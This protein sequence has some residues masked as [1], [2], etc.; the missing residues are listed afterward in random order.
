[1]NNIIIYIILLLYYE[2]I[3]IV[4]VSLGTGNLKVTCYFV[5]NHLSHGILILKVQNK[6]KKILNSHDPSEYIIHR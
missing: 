4:L 2:E 5:T 3:L 1:V 6:E